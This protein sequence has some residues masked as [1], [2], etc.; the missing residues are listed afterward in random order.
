LKHSEY[1]DKR[2]PWILDA[3][4]VTNIRRD[5]RRE[6]NNKVDQRETESPK[7]PINGAYHQ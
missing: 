6:P 5:K 1:I 4:P 7:H 3:V 2:S